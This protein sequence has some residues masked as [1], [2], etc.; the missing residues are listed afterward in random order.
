[1][2]KIL[3]IVTVAAG[4]GMSAF[5]QGQFNF[6]TT[7]GRL[8]WDDWSALAFKPDPSNNV[9]F[10]F[11]TGTRLID[12]VAAQTATN[13]TGI[14]N[15]ASVSTVWTDLLTDPNYHLA[16]NTVGGGLVVNPTSLTG[17]IT[18][19][20]FVATNSPGS[21]TITV[22]VIGW[23][24]AFANPLLAAAAGGVVGWS[25]AFTYTIG[26]PGGA[27]AQ[28]FN[29]APNAIV[30]FGV[31]PVPEPTTFALAGLGAATLL[32]FRRRKQ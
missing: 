9:A 4:I 24:A 30:A 11:G 23:S 31:V 13:A 25:T 7:A 19:S 18:G 6:S 14:P 28:A 21:G 15:G 8:I 10:L 2:K 27:V 17:G 32:I 20:T 5:G 22:F 29:V 16:T 26:S 3:L 1:M 12:A